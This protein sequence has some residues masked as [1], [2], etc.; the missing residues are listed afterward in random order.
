M[1]KVVLY[2]CIPKFHGR[3]GRVAT[4]ELSKCCCF[5]AVGDSRNILHSNSTGLPVAFEDCLLYKLGLFGESRIIGASTEDELDL[6][7]NS[8]KFA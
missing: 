8:R 5:D 2:P 4:A 3:G 1:T 7:S 6:G